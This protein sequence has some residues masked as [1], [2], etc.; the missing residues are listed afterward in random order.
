[1]ILEFEMI[2]R[3]FVLI[4]DFVHALIYPESPFPADEHRFEMAAFV[5]LLIFLPAILLLCCFAWV[6]IFLAVIE[7]FVRFCIS[8][9]KETASRIVRGCSLIRTLWLYSAS[10]RRLTDQSI[11]GHALWDRWVDGI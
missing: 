9:V 4:F 11:E 3:L 2:F 1:V 7:F 10:G 6:V 8:L 5:R